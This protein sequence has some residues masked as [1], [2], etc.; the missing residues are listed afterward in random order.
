MY[1]SLFNHLSQYA[2]YA[3]NPKQH[4]LRQ[5]YTMEQDFVFNIAKINA[6]ASKDL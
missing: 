4:Q 1:H 5:G 3:I 2:K 6:S